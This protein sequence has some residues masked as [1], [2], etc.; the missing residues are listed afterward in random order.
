MA[1]NSI[2]IKMPLNWFKSIL[3][4]STPPVSAGLF[5]SYF[6]N[7]RSAHQGQVYLHVDNNACV[8]DYRHSCNSRLRGR[9]RGFCTL[10]TPYIPIPLNTFSNLFLKYGTFSAFTVSSL[11]TLNAIHP[12][13]TAIL[14]MLENMILPR[15]WP[16]FL[17]FFPTRSSKAASR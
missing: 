5:G 1:A 12:K 6:A 10:V 17:S 3:K 14:M 13:S 15:E 7:Q 16:Y 9:E 4:G 11:S 8:E 2:K